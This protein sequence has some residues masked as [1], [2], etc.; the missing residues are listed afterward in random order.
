ML[1]C[2]NLKNIGGPRA[3]WGGGELSIG[4]PKATPKVYKLTPM[5][6]IQT[7]GQVERLPSVLIA[8]PATPNVDETHCF[9]FGLD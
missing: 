7:N 1:K 6:A 5:Q 4:G 8:T 9:Q 3:P 2:A